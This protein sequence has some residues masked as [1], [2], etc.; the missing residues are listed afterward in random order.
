MNPPSGDLEVFLDETP[1][2][3]RG[4]EGRPGLGLAI[5]PERQIQDVG[6]DREPCIR[7]RAAADGRQQTRPAPGG[8]GDSGASAS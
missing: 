3:T 1:G 2:E 5:A 8:G 6:E 4:A 7:T